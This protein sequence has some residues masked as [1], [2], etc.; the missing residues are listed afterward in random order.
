MVT[1][2]ICTSKD[3]LG[4][5]WSDVY[6]CARTNIYI[7]I[8]IYIHIHIHVLEHPPPPR[9]F[10]LAVSDKKMKDDGIEALKAMLQ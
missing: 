6:D 5:G 1:E 8:Y 2:S 3:T 4:F 10:Q 7:Y 9:D